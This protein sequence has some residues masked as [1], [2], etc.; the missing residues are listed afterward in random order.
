MFE[1]SKIT[2]QH[3]SQVESILLSRSLKSISDETVHSLGLSVARKQFNLPIPRP[4]YVLLLSCSTNL[5]LKAKILQSF[6]SV[7]RLEILT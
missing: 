5:G 1:F 4:N 6:G 3:G 2:R 7:S